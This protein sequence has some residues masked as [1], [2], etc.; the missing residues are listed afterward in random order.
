MKKTAGANSPNSKPRSSFI[1]EVARSERC[2]KTTRTAPNKRKGESSPLRY[3]PSTG[4]TA[5][6]NTTKTV[7]TTILAGMSQRGGEVAGLP[8]S[9]DFVGCA[10]HEQEH[11]DEGDER[12]QG[13]GHQGHTQELE[14]D[15]GGREAHTAGAQRREP[16]SP[17]TGAKGVSQTEDG[18]RNR[19]QEHADRGG[20]REG[21]P[22][23]QGQE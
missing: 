14:D 12:R 4:A 21:C 15:G 23:I 10:G 7:A 19:A 20:G 3:G 5:V 16:G 17:S 22:M 1:A 6:S 11:N 13:G 2:T 8:L 9:S 18:L